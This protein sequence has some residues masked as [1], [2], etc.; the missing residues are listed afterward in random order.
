MQSLALIAAFSAIYQGIGAGA[1]E[2]DEASRAFVSSVAWITWKVLASATI[3]LL[4]LLFVYGIYALSFMRE[5]GI[6]ARKPVLPLVVAGALAAVVI[7]QLHV[8]GGWVPV[9][10]VA[11]L[12]SRSHAVVYT[13][14]VAAVPWL[15][16]AWLVQ[17][18]CQ[19]FPHPEVTRAAAAS[20]VT[21]TGLRNIWD[22]ISRVV[23][24]FA[25]G[26]VAAL[27][28]SGA[29]RLAFLSAH[30]PCGAQ[31]HSSS[32]P[33]GLVC[34]EDFP[35]TYVL[36]YGAA[37]AVFLLVISIPMVVTWRNRAIAWVLASNPPPAGAPDQKWSED[38]VRLEK[39]LHLDIPFLR[40]P[41][42]LLSVLLPLVT[43]LLAAFLPQLA[44]KG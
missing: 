15:A 21:F 31:A 19:R 42:T 9:L 25:C 39:L 13:G 14:L 29:L 43:S 27:L 16:V 18:A 7:W 3:T 6:W 33:G 5:G 17:D 1:A 4:V 38:Q 28:T 23:G 36:L 35:A 11:D 24:V 10:P 32:R 30:E 8:K 44:G 2:A 37:F 22:H 40:N 12:P 20:E 41:I 26:V 34:A